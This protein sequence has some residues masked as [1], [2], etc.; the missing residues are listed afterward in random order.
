MKTI[1]IFEGFWVALFLWSLQ[2]EQTMPFQSRQLSSSANCGHDLHVVTYQRGRSLL[3]SFNN[4]DGPET[5]ETDNGRVDQNAVT[6][7]T[8]KSLQLLTVAV[9]IFFV[10][11][12]GL[13][14]D[15]LLPAPSSTSVQS[16][17]M[18]QRLNADEIL[19]ADFNRYD[20]SVSF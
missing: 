16:Q 7:D 20:S 13:A 6:F 3:M 12:V 5:V 8:F 17:K 11:L 19:Q 15:Q 1:S 4:D 10:A 2:I 18:P 9:S 14:G